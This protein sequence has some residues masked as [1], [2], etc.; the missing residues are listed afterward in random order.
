MFYRSKP[1]VV[2]NY[3]NVKA[4]AGGEVNLQTSIHSN[5]NEDLSRVGVS[6]PESA[7]LS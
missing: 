6:R 7:M 5:D 1:K 4:S 3:L 2:M